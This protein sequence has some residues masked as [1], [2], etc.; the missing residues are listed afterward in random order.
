MEQKIFLNVRKN[1]GPFYKNPFQ[2]LEQ[3][4]LIAAENA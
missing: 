2:S 1:W 3:S 4:G